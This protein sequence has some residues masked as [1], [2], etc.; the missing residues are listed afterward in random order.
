MT[1]PGM[2]DI[3]YW[4]SDMKHEPQRGATSGGD[5]VHIL[6][7]PIYVEDAEPGD[8]IA[9]EIMDLELRINSDGKTYGSNAAAWW[10]FQARI[11]KEDGT[12]FVSG[13][14]VSSENDEYITIYEM[15]TEDG[16]AY[17]VPL[18]QY[19]WPII[20]D[21]NGTVRT[22]IAYPGTCVPHDPHG[23]TENVSS[24]VTNMGWKK[25]ENITYIDD[26]FR[27]KIPVNMHIGCM[28]LAPESHSYVDSIPPL[29]VRVFLWG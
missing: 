1:L 11:P 24:A 28:G 4:S 7:G 6:T 9:V 3:Y 20:E 18:Y 2:E 5:G 22:S 27:A 15:V 10:G 13:S 26:V 17:A 23:S 29:P 25:E 21:P 19:Q 14:N 16:T 8:M 12:A